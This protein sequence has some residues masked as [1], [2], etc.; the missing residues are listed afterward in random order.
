MAGN[1]FSLIMLGF[2]ERTKLG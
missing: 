2:E 1:L